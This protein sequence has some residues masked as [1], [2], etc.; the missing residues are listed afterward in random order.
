MSYTAKFT[1]N[2]EWC[3]WRLTWR[4]LNDDESLNTP[5]QDIITKIWKPTLIFENTKRKER[6]PVDEKARFSIR[7]RGPFTLAPDDETHEAAYYK[8]TENSVTYTRDFYLRFGCD[9]EL[10]NYPFDTQ[11]CKIGL[12]KQHK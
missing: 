2:L 1:L 10:Q 8:G 12:K 3:D 11:E 4:D 6:T 7:I 5:S 9:F